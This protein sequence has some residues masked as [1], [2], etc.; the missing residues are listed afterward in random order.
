MLHTFMCGVRCR[1]LA[2]CSRTPHTRQCWLRQCTSAVAICIC[3]G[4]ISLSISLLQKNSITVAFVLHAFSI[5][6]LHVGIGGLVKKTSCSFVGLPE[7]THSRQPYLIPN[8]TVI[9]SGSC[10]DAAGGS[11]FCAATAME[12]SVHVFGI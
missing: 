4:Q 6:T 3:N 2:F 11:Y 1:A 8:R 7:Y 10:A 5:L 9:I 12:Y